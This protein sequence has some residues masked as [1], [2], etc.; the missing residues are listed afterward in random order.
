MARLTRFLDALMRWG[1]GLCATLLILLALLVSLGRYLAP[2]VGEYTGP[3]SAKASQLLGVPV[4]V[5]SLEG[6]WH[7]LAPIVSAR[8]VSVGSGPGAI[9]LERVQVVPSLWRSLLGLSLHIAYL[10][11]DGL[12]LSLEQGSDGQWALKGLPDRP[13]DAPFDPAQ[14]LAQLDRVAELSLAD[15]QLTLKPQGH[16][17]LVLSYLALSLRNQA[18]GQ[19]LALRGNLPDGQPLAAEVDARVD[20]GDWRQSTL[21]AYLSLP[22]SNWAAWL[23]P[24]LLHGWNLATLKAGGEL[25]AQWQAGELRS[26]AL[27]LNAPEVR[28]GYQQREPSEARDVALNAWVRRGDEGYEVLV[29]SLAMTLQDKR[30]ES[31]LRVHQGAGDD[32]PVWQLQADRV[33]LGPLTPLIDAWAPLPA[34][35]A[36]AVDSL[37]LTGAL[38]NLQLEWYPQAEGDRRLGFA[39]NLEQLGFKAYHG[40]PGAGNVSGS[41]SGDLGHGELRLATSDFMLHLYPIFAKPWYYPKANALLTWRLDHDA[42]TLAAPAIRVQG[43]EGQIAGDFN[44]YLPFAPEAEP[45]MDLRVGLTH[46]DGS[47]TPKYLPDLLPPSVADWLRNAQI[48]GQVDEGYFQYQGS[49]AKGAPE[50]ARSISLFFKVHDAALAF[51][52]GWPRAERVDG[53]VYIQDG[54]VR[55]LADHGQVLGAQVSAVDVRVPHVPS[56]QTTH[57][58]VDGRFDGTLADGINLLQT[59]PIGTAELFA[60]W[61]GAGPLKGALTLDVPLVKGQAPAVQVDFATEGARLKIS[62]PALELSQLKGDF[63]FDLARGLSGQNISAQ[64]FGKPVAVQVF[65]EGKGGAASTR[66]AARGQVG[67]KALADWLAYTGSLPASGEIPYQLQVW[68]GSD[69]RL[70]VD[71]DLAGLAVSLPEPFGK[72]ASEPRPSRFELSLSGPDRLARLRY[73]DVANAVYLAPG[74]NAANG[75]GELQLGTQPAQLPSDKGLRVRGSLARLDVAAWKNHSDTYVGNDAAGSPRQWLNSINVSIGQLSGIGTTLDQAR[76]SLAP[77]A[78]N[79]WALAVDSQQVTGQATVPGDKAAP[80]DVR[81]QAVHLPPAAPPEPEG[82][83]P[84]DSPDPLASIDPRSLPAVNLAIDQLWQGDEPLGAWSLKMRPNEKGVAL[85]DIDFGLKGMQLRGSGSWEGSP[86]ASV[87]WFKGQVAG[88]NM[89]DVLK[90]WK[91]APSVTSES[92]VIDVDGRW[93]GSPAWL[94]P[95]RFSGSLDAQFKRGQFVEVE[96]GAQALRVFGLLNFNSIGRR[97]RLDFSDLLGKGLSYDEVKGRLA[98]SDGV[99]VTRRPITL[100]GPSSNLEMDGTLDMAADR[101]DA[102]LLVTLP[103]SNNLPIAALIVGAPAIGGALF[104]ADKLLGDRVARFASVQYKVEGSLKDPK[105]SFDKP[106]RKPQ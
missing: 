64:A 26:A 51:Q 2:L 59:A 48:Q 22:Q 66:I 75:R 85:S 1:L 55:I 10:E 70:S 35:A 53:R 40:A 19:R 38:R 3:A 62:R 28:G 6:R 94:S 9:H 43:P 101:I 103:V 67:A 52:P 7:G 21:K 82:S 20:A 49:L 58:L 97:L 39:A 46:G 99:Y 76:V 90:A 34:A 23:P 84:A 93:P 89:G 54:D 79:G 42:F 17:P 77:T 71:T 65:A 33:D 15:T 102:K 73:G 80:L 92:F 25:W 30:W 12:S 83:E 50:H 91:F 106:F 18:G 5:G 100:T 87:S 105:V 11:I 37:A 63:R 95:K 8:D 32:G 72:A 86:G 16:D 13:R 27:R 104:L 14:A 47:F 74:G 41:I 57:L 81:L 44:I 98:A 29:D 96:G 61:E 69:S 31:H 56:N 24:G 88:K 68:L 60:G 36:Q 45:Y 78:D 4:Q